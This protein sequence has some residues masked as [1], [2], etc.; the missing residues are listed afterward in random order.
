MG[1]LR[2]LGCGGTITSSADDSGVR[3]GHG[4]IGSVLSGTTIQGSEI[5]YVDVTT[6]SSS[7]MTPAVMRTLAERVLE[8]ERDGVSGVVITHGTDT[9]EETAYALAAMVRPSMPVVL[10][11]AMRGPGEPGADGQANLRDALLVA[12]LPACAFG[13]IVSIAGEIHDPRWVTKSDTSRI[14]AFTSPGAGPVGGVTEGVVSMWSVPDEAFLRTYLGL[15][16]ELAARVE[17]IWSAAGMDGLLI[18][19]AAR[20]ADGLVIAGTGGGHLS[21]AA[22]EAAR[23]AAREIPVVLA[24][25]CGSG[26]TLSRTYGGVGSEI[27]MLAH[28]LLRAGRL[29][30]VKARLRLMIALALGL[31]PRRHFPA[32]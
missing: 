23:D 22:A 12:A 13:P 15:P 24:S 1:I 3:S 29:S 20:A 2:V 30:P 9:L 4:S 10:T 26:A 17:L 7:A 8:A 19:A 5:E 25:R 14:S 28:G 11:G 18:N 31:D 6:M 27:D 16:S 21:P 32:L